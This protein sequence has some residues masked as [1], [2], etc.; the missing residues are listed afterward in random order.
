MQMIRRPPP[1]RAFAAPTYWV[2]RLKRGMTPEGMT[3]GGTKLFC[4]CHR[5]K[6]S[7][8]V[9]GLFAEMLAAVEQEYRK[10]DCEQRTQDGTETPIRFPVV[11]H[12][13]LR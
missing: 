1:H 10:G 3:I 9:D 7:I 12:G 4:R 2:P 13:N 6:V 8:A 11:R 5:G